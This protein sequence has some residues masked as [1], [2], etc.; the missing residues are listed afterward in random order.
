MI[1]KLYNRFDHTEKLINIRN[2][3]QMNS[4]SQWERNL[5]YLVIDMNDVVVMGDTIAHFID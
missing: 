2:K 4:L 1:I 5:I 3:K